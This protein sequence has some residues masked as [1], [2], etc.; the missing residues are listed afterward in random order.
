MVPAYSYS[1][2]CEELL[3]YFKKQSNN[4]KQ[5]EI[6]MVGILFARPGSPIAK[7]QIIPNLDY[8]HHRSGN[9]IDFFCAGYGMYWE[10]WKDIFPDQQVVGRGQYRNWLY[11]TEKFNNFREEIERMSTWRY[12]GSV[13]LLLTNAK[14]DPINDTAFLDCSSCIVCNIEKMLGSGAIL[15]VETFFEEIF[16]FA[17]SSNDT[18]PTWGF[19]DSKGLSIGGSAF[20]R[21]VLSLLPKHFGQE[22]EKLE[23]FAIQDVSI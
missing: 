19:S 8:F 20:K 22:V 13:D 21:F 5:L 3:W 1:K 6:K 7:R 10:N 2:I 23:H 16:R 12:S 17:E 18:D 15:S 9:N 4:G 14:Y 11:S